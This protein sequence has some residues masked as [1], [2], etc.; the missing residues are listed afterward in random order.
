MRNSRNGERMSSGLAASQSWRAGERWMSCDWEE[1]NV[2]Q[3]PRKLKSSWFPWRIMESLRNEAPATS[4]SGGTGGTENCKWAKYLYKQHFDT[5]IPASTVAETWVFTFRWGLT[6]ELLNWGAGM[7]ESQGARAKAGELSESWYTE[8]WTPRP[9]SHTYLPECR[10]PG[11]STLGKKLAGVS[12]KK[13]TSP[14]DTESW[15]PSERAKAV[16]PTVKPTTNTYSPGKHSFRPTFQWP[17]LKYQLTTKDHQAFEK[18]SVVQKKQTE[19][20]R[21]NS[22]GIMK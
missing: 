12:Q 8:P 22:E 18:T 5:H 19:V 2:C 9:H 15:V 17:M 1:A 14:T 7:V 20:N 10:Q 16:L 6:R 4:E 13:A 11:L 21:K 3:W